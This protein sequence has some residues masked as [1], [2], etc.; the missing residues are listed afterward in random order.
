M[1]KI[2]LCPES[3]L[4]NKYWWT[5]D[6]GALA[7]C[8]VV[9]WFASGIVL[10]MI[11]ADISRYTVAAADW[12]RQL[13][14][15]Q[16]EVEKF[17][18]LDQEVGLLNRKIDALKRIT[19]SKIDKILPIVVADQLQTL[20]PEGVWFHQLSFGEDKVLRIK[21]ASTDSLLISE[22]LLGLRETMNPETV[23]SDVRT[24]LGFQKVTVKEIKE[25]RVDPA[26]NDLKNVLIF[27]ASGIV[28]EKK[29][30]VVVPVVAAPAPRMKNGSWF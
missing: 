19:V 16:P 10:N 22:F 2:Q 20:R 13:A 5:L 27:E 14:E 11:Q 23:T 3:E 7:V 4:E 15:I 18:G 28:E 21:G 1:L 17:K 25:S 30:S 24:Q 12:S 8:A 26:F 9:S 6:L 29:S